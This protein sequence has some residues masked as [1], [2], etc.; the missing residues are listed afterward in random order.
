ML[1]RRDYWFKNSYIDLLVRGIM[2]SKDI[3]ICSLGISISQILINFHYL[4]LFKSKRI[5]EAA[6]P[7][8]H[9]NKPLPLLFVIYDRNEKLS[10]DFFNR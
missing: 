4:D 3:L 2:V 9:N 6:E 10:N 8:Q 7:I 5:A 1:Q